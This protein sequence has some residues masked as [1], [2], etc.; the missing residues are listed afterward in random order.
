MGLVGA[1]TLMHDSSGLSARLWDA[2][3]LVGLRRLLFT[4]WEGSFV[5]DGRESLAV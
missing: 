1:G 4:G 5:L 2:V 3:G